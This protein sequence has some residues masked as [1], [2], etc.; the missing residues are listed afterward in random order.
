MV[1]LLC[2]LCPSVLPIPMFIIPHTNQ[3]TLAD[4]S[5]W[6]SMTEDIC[7][8]TEVPLVKI[9]G[10]AD[11]KN[12]SFFEKKCQIMG[13][14]QL[15]WTFL[16]GLHGQTRVRTACICLLD[17]THAMDCLMVGCSC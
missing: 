13:K 9:A 12:L 10:D 6:L 5:E 7:M 8:K 14:M 17:L 16:V 3:Y 2:G 1:G 15:G 11:A 4:Q